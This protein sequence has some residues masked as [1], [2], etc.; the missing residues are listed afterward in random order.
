MNYLYTKLLCF[1]FSAVISLDVYAA[2]FQIHVNDEKLKMFIGKSGLLFFIIIIFCIAFKCFRDYR[3]MQDTPTSKIRSCVQGVVELEGIQDN[4]DGHIML[5]PLTKQAC[6]WYEYTINKNEGK[7][8]KRIAGEV[9]QAF[10]IITD[11]TGTCIIDPKYADVETPHKITWR[12]FSKDTPYGS[13]NFFSSF[14]NYVFTERYMVPKEYIYA[15]GMFYTED[16][17][18]YLRRFG[19][20]QAG[21]VFVLSAIKQQQ[22]I[23]RYKK[24]FIGFIILFLI[25]VAV[26]FLL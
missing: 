2:T 23:N 7:K 16:Q 15:L 6:T 14:G 3:L 12:G 9:S 21:K 17:K 8:T 22:L 4:L 13:S 10:F 25:L 24:Q 19:L 20:Q 5:S 26:Y 11:G 1:L 18:N